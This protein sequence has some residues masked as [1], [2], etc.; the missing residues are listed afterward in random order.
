MPVKRG[1]GN[2]YA[3]METS[4]PVDKQIIA[5][6]VL[7]ARI[8]LALRQPFLASALMRLPVRAIDGFSWCPTMATDGYHL[9]YSPEWVATL[10]AA[11][12]RGVLAHELLHVLFDHPGRLGSRNHE[13]WNVACDHVINLLLLELGFRLPAGGSADRRF[14]G[15]TADEIYDRLAQK[16]GAIGRSTAVHQ[17]P[18]GS[19]EDTPGMC[20]D[21][22]P[23]LIAA[24]DPRV[25][26][27]QDGDMPD[28]EARRDLQRELRI[29]AM[30]KLQ[31]TGAASFHREFAAVKSEMVD[32]RALLRAFLSDRIRDDWSLW[33]YSKR[34]V[35]RGLFMPSVGVEAP[36]NLVFAID[37]SGSMSDKVLTGIIGELRGFRET[38][39]TRLTV[40]QCDAVIH[41]EQT[42]GEMDGTEIPPRMRIH[43]RGGTDFRPVFN[44]IESR[45][46]GCVLLF[47]T[48]GFG[49]FPTVRPSYPVLWLLTPPHLETERIP[50]G[51][52]VALPF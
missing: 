22:G 47:A 24:D 26:P 37:T 8:Q 11:E 12:I 4:L 45:G 44:W 18:D 39:P 30:Q 9:F 10:Q 17:V 48:D 33:P 14:Y 42:F 32:W 15:L 35:H 41:S 51:A 7:Q 25:R 40:L 28:L 36:G 49:T 6:R 2:S 31:G 16:I 46:E 3:I 21:I 27:V 19:S 20:P 34:Y 23:D 52:S 43:G 38:F 50:F 1:I 13:I 5:E 29:D